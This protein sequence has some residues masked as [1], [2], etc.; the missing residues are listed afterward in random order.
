MNTTRTY[1]VIDAG[2][3]IITT[4][5]WGMAE[6]TWVARRLRYKPEHRYNVKMFAAEQ[7]R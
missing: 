5:E 6:D 4:T 1:F 2:T 3:I 7:V